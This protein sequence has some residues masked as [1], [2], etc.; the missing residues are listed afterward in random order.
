MRCDLCGEEGAV[1]VVAG[2][3]GAGS[4]CVE[5]LTGKLPYPFKESLVGLNLNSCA[6]G[7]GRERT[8]RVP[9]R[10]TCLTS[11]SP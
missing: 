3:I 8:G 7:A 10:S 6:M 2:E 11:D 1:E 4:Y 5:C 9:I